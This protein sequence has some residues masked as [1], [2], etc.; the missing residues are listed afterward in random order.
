M[1]EDDS[2]KEEEETW[3]EKFVLELKG[4]TNFIKDENTFFV[5]GE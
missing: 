4:Q 1:K 3:L 2:E 5:N